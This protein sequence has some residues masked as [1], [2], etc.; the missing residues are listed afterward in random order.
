MLLLDWSTSIREMQYKLM[1]QCSSIVLFCKMNNIKCKVFAFTSNKQALEKYF[2]HIKLYENT[3]TFKTEK[4][5]L[6]ELL[7][8]EGDTSTKIKKFL[9]LKGCYLN[10]M[11]LNSTPLNIALLNLTTVLKKMYAPDKQVSLIILTDGISD[12]LA[13]ENIN[14]YTNFDYVMDMDSNYIYKDICFVDLTKIYDFLLLRLKR[15]IPHLNVLTI[16][17]TPNK[18]IK[19]NLFNEGMLYLKNQQRKENIITMY[20]KKNYVLINYKYFSCIFYF[21]NTYHS[22]EKKDM[23]LND[24]KINTNEK[25]SLK[26][27]SNILR[28]LNNS[29]STLAIKKIAECI[30]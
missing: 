9:A 2:T 10:Y 19:A 3:D 14:I 24:M 20:N 15:I 6:L 7:N 26:V 5:L 29:I 12:H 11:E 28:T 21:Q 1:V 25:N 27:T 18:K 22:D 23:L 16:F 4:H 8:T 13:P 17:L 30:A